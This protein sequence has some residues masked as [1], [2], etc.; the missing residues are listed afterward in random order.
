MMPD[1]DRALLQR[2]ERLLHDIKGANERRDARVELINNRV[3]GIGALLFAFASIAV[4]I[5]AAYGIKRAGSD[6][7]DI[8]GY[9]ALTLVFLAVIHS[10]SKEFFRDPLIEHERREVNAQRLRDGLAPIRDPTFLELV[11]GYLLVLLF[12]GLVVGFFGGICAVGADVLF[13]SKSF[14]LIAQ[15]GLAAAV[16]SFLLFG[17]TLSTFDWLG[18]LKSSREEKRKAKAKAKIKK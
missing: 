16:A 14:G 2:V 1:D 17:M 18:N 8:V 10:G 7:I 11:A 3:A 9:V 6:V 13:L 15:W 5:G 12:G 4:I